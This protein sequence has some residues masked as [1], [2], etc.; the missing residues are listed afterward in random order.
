LCRGLFIPEEGH[1]FGSI[2]YSQIEYRILCHFAMGNGSTEIRKA[3]NE[4]PNL[5][6]H[7]WCADFVGLQGKEG[8]SLAK[9]INFGVIYGQGAKKTAQALGLDLDAA[10]SFLQKYN[11]KMPF[12]KNYCK[13][14]YVSC[15]TS[16]LGKNYFRPT[17]T[18]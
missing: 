15:R 14:G 7:Q 17:T 6:V 10:K 16:R 4:N 8:R 1:L 9:A 18:L 5:D 2:D 12:A 13:R 11:E 3:F